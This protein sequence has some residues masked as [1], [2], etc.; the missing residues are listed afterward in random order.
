MNAP[1]DFDRFIAVDW[2]GARG[3]YDGIAVAECRPGWS[4]PTL[5]QPPGARW[6]RRDFVAWMDAIG[7]TGDRVLVGIDCAFALPAAASEIM[8]GGPHDAPALWDHIDGNCADAEDYYGGDFASGPGRAALFWHAGPRPAQFVEHRRATELACAAAG[9]GAPESP[10]KLIGAKQ[11]GKGAL[12]GMRVLARLRNRLGD[13]FAVWP[14]DPPGA[15]I[16]CVELYPR[17]FLRMAGFGNR[18]VRKL[19]DLDQCLAALGSAPYRQGAPMS[20][21]VTD[22]LVAAAGLRRIAADPAIWS[23][24]GLDG[25]ARRTEG[26]IFGVC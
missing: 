13:R 18:K 16:V 7:E 12:A 20:D 26:W 11:V 22:A 15:G 14:F 24:T 25:L 21:H 4:A 2:S 10:L 6:S 8:L 17:L 23:P 3:R 9:L 1:P 5:A 19:D